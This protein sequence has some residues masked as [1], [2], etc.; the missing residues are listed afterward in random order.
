MCKKFAFWAALGLGAFAVLSLTRV[1]SYAGT[2]WSKVKVTA[3]RQ[4]PVEFEI[5]RLRN[6]VGQLVPD[7]KKNRSMVAE[8]IVAIDNLRQE[9]T[10]TR[11]NLDKQKSDLLRMARDVESGETQLVYGGRTYTVE[12]IKDKLAKDLASFKRAETELKA[13]EQMLDAKE[14]SLDTARE[15]LATLMEQKQELEVAIAQ[16]EAEAKTVKLAQTR[17]QF[18]FDDSRLSEI[19]RSLAELRTRLKV[20]ITELELE[21]QYSSDPIKAEKAKPAADVAR[22]VREY[23]QPSSVQK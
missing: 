3:Q 19:K 16:L 10:F 12:R 4:V 17:S 23:L 15:Q 6:E 18:T 8:E 14:R 9:I 2:A 11:S 21:G 22:E 13:R 5:E 20:E 7:M 1:G